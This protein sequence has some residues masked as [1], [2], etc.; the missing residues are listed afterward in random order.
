V[1]FE[2]SIF[3]LPFALQGAWLAA[4]G[5]PAPRTLLLIAVCAVA[6]R[7]AAMAFN[8]LVDARL[9]R[10][11]PRTRDRE[12][13]AGRL[14]RA[15]VA[16]LVLAA[17]GVFV[18]G[19]LALNPLCGRLALP[20]LAVL[21]GYSLT[22]RFTFL[23]HLV[24]GLALA[25][26]PLGAWLAVRGDLRGDLAVPLLLAAAALAWVA[27]FD[28]IYATQDAAFDRRAGLHSV[29]ARFGIP[30]ALALSRALH[31]STVVLLGLLWARAE[32]SW[33]YLAAI[34]LAAGLLVWEHRLVKPDDLSRV[35]LAFF[36]L[37]GWIGV[38]LFAGLACDLHFWSGA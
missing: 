30:A 20:V 37:N 10:E 22:K 18:A 38:G 17:A 11:N 26:A 36:T 13:P 15:R 23:A 1:A 16:L 19:A 7:T 3:A 9:D 29:P 25:L 14:S 27:G 8:R 34:A 6:A 33:A 5:M 32:L 31:V 2:H 35:N 24:L 21:L 28:L 4:R 12:L